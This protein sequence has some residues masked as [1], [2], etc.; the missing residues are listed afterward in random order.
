MHVVLS[1]LVMMN[2]TIVARFVQLVHPFKIKW[3]FIKTIDKADYFDY[4]YIKYIFALII[5]YNVICF[6]IID[7][8]L[9]YPPWILFIWWWE[10]FTSRRFK[11]ALIISIVDMF[12]YSY[13]CNF[14]SPLLIPNVIWSIYIVYLGIW[15]QNCISNFL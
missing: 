13:L 9:L 8:L 14:L 15:Y 10:L 1:A 6:S 2:L 5:I 11:L 4:N 7:T 12:G 3:T